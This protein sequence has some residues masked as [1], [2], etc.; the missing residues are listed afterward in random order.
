MEFPDPPPAV[1]KTSLVGPIV[2]NL[3][4]LAL[5]LRQVHSLEDAGLIFGVLVVI[6]GL[7]LLI[8]VFYPKLRWLRAFLLAALL[9]GLVLVGLGAYVL[10]GLRRSPW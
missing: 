1:E 2:V 8:R 3:S 4:L 5:A 6:N 9:V 10:S 7:G